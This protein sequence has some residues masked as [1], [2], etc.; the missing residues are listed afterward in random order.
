MLFLHLKIIYSNNNTQMRPL[1][2][3]LIQCFPILDLFRS[4]EKKIHLSY[5]LLE[6]IYFL[7]FFHSYLYFNFLLQR[8]IIILHLFFNYRFF[9]YSISFLSLFLFCHLP[10]IIHLFQ[11]FSKTFRIQKLFNYHLFFLK[12][13]LNYQLFKRLIF[14]INVIGFKDCQ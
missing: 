8:L 7:L 13:I 2:K 12:K 1:K 3:L 14:V 4:V 6:K 5:F 10:F 11:F 9:H